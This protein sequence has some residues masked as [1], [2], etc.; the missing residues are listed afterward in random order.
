MA[1]RSQWPIEPV[2]PQHAM[3]WSLAATFSLIEVPIGE[4]ISLRVSAARDQAQI[5]STSAAI[6]AFGALGEVGPLVMARC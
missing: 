4:E 3:D 2:K 5:E 6:A 1:R